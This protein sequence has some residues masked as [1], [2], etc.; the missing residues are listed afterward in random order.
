MSRVKSRRRRPQAGAGD[1]NAGARPGGRLSRRW[2]SQCDVGTWT[3]E[4]PPPAPALP[5]TAAARPAA[6][7]SLPLE[8][9]TPGDRPARRVEVLARA[10][11]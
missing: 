4:G 9:P 5:P 10:R 6:Q 1:M 3:E 7:R 11:R 8:I 2:R